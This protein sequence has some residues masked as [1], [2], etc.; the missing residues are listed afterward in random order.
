MPTFA[1]GTFL[2]WTGGGQRK[3]FLDAIYDYLCIVDPVTGE[4]G[5]GLAQSWSV[6]RDGLAWTFNLRAGVHF[7]RGYGE[8]GAADVA[9]SIT[10]IIRPTARAGP[11]S[12]LRR[13]IKEIATPN[14]RTVVIHL[15][16]PDPELAKGYLANAQQV[17]IVCARHIEEAGERAANEAPVG[18]GPF[19]LEFFRRDFRD[20]PRLAQ[21]RAEHLARQTRVP[22]SG[23]SGSS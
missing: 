6:T 12:P 23:L 3:A 21:G 13:L 17:G 15:T 5:P 14:A 10:Q 19:E 7:Q 18:S 20:P 2:P 1:E 8:V 11:S 22:Q 16:R 9:F 4:P